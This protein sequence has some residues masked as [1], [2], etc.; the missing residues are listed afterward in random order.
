MNVIAKN[1]EFKI[2]RLVKYDVWKDGKEMY[3][4]YTHSKKKAAA[5]AKFTCFSIVQKTHVQNIET[6][7]NEWRGKK[8]E[9]KSTEKH[10]TDVV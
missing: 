10:I 9:P 2:V 1:I 4:S 7:S 6:K 8:H 5:P 3:S